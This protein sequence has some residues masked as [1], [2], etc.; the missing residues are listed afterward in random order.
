MADSPYIVEVT[1]ENYAQV[2]EASFQVPVL[3]DFWA[4]W[5]QPCQILMPTL[6]KLAAEFGGK[7]LLGKLNTEEQQELAAQFGIRSIPTVKLFRDGQ[8]VDEFLGALPEGEIRNFLHKHLPRE[9]DQAIQEA[10]QLSRSGDGEGAIAVL[11]QAQHEDPDNHR[12]TTALAQALA[13]G[14][15][16][17]AAAALLDGLPS[18]EQEKP[19]VVMLKSRLHFEGLAAAAPD[20]TE[21]KTRLTANENDS[22]ARFLLAAQYVAK[23][24]YDA[25][26]EMLL[27][28]MRRDRNY[29]DDAARQTLVKI[30]ELLGDDT[31]VPRYRSRMA[32]LLY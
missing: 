15:D 12:V 25:A 11:K 23:Q 18:D 9:S 8:P 21:L 1:G 10:A 7:F 3:I 17:A 19:D 20:A 16:A 6:A 22:E 32:Q 2:M 13:A 5:C 14:G 31:R 24:D 27:E 4:S 26:V 29:S 30:F 28:L